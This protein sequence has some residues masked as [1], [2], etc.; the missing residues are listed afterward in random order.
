VR[1]EAIACETPAALGVPLSRLSTADIA[2][3]VRRKG[4]VA[5]ISDS[6]VWRWLHADAIRPWQHRCWVFPRDPDFERKA[7]RILD[8][9]QGRWN[10]RRLRQDEF[11]ISAD[12]K[13]SIQ[14][15]KRLHA[16]IPPQPGAAAQ[17]EHEYKRLGAWA[18]LA[19]LDVK[20]VKV[21]G[22]CR[23]HS[24]IVAFDSLVDKVMTRAPYRRAR[25]VFWIVDNGSSHRGLAC[26]RRLQRKYPTIRVVHSPVHASWLNQVEIYF[27]V[28]QRKALTPN[29]FSTMDGLAERI[30]R[31][32]R[33]FEMIARPFEWKF[34][35]KDLCQLLAKCQPTAHAQAA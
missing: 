1:I 13:T 12:E 2:N 7:G 24:G 26:V 35:R 27:S 5:K 10:G 16:T 29:D 19:A 22:I 8:L 9:Y 14:A 31:F 18:Y 15:R 3:Y 17:V 34:T 33:Y 11:V 25:R 23:R 20:R 6:T 30:L 32:E 4:V 28:L 21:F